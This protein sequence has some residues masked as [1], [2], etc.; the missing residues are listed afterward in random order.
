MIIWSACMTVYR[1]HA[2]CPL[3]SLEGI[4]SLGS[5]VIADCEPACV[6]LELNGGFLQEPQMLL[7]AEP[8]F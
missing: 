7:A 3:R 4:E 8:T 6:Y 2:C 5:G 1:V